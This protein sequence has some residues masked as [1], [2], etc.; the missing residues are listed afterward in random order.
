VIAIVQQNAELARD[1]VAHLPGR[2]PETH[3]CIA[4]DALK[5]A[6]ITN[7]E[8]ISAETKKRLGPILSKYC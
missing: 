2:L 5:Y 1:I 3:N 8:Y 4:A 7:Q 6:I